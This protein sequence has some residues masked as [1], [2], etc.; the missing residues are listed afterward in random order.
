MKKVFLFV[1]IS[2]IFS[3][4][5]AHPPKNIEIKYNL[6][7]DLVEVSIFHGS[8]N[9]EKHYINEIHLWVN[10]RKIVKQT[11]LTQFEGEKQFFK[12]IIPNLKNG[13]LIEVI[14]KCSVY[15]SKKV[16]VEIE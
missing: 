11:Y 7:K 9:I 13:D 3:F 1:I 4:I 6:E 10:G 15:G 16:K 5:I 8:N 12:Y 14:A 2:I